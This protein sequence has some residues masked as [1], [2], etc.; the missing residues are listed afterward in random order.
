MCNPCSSFWHIFVAIPWDKVTDSSLKKSKE[1][2]DALIE[3]DFEQFK[4]LIDAGATF[5]YTTEEG[6]SIVHKLIGPE[7]AEYLMYVDQKGLLFSAKKNAPSFWANE[8]GY[9]DLEKKD[10]EGNT[11][12]YYACAK[13]NINTIEMLIKKY[14][15]K[16]DDPNKDGNIPLFE[17]V[18]HNKIEILK[19][20]KENTTPEKWQKMCT[21]YKNKKDESL[22][23]LICK[24]GNREQADYILEQFPDLKNTQNNE[25]QTPLHVAI[26]NKNSDII[27]ILLDSN[28]DLQ[29]KD[30]Y[31]NTSAM[32]ALKDNDIKTVKSI[33]EKE[34]TVLNIPNN[35]KETPLK[36]AFEKKQY[37]LA[38]L[39]INNNAS[40]DFTDKDG[41]TPL[42]YAVIQ[43][44]KHLVDL[45]I[46]KNPKAADIQNNNQ[47]APL[48][49]AIK[50]EAY[51][52][53]ELLIA[54]NAN[55]FFK[56]SEGYT[57]L[58]LAVIQQNIKLVGLIIEKNR[59]TTE[60][61]D[62]NNKT[63]FQIACDQK[64][65]GGKEYFATHLP[66]NNKYLHELLDTHKIDYALF[67]K[68]LEKNPS[69]LFTTTL[70]GNTPLLTAITKNDLDAVKIILNSSE[71]KTI[72]SLVNKPNYEQNTC[73][74][75]A[76]KNLKTNNGPKEKEIVTLLLPYTNCVDEQ[77]NKLI[78]N[79]DGES[80]LDLALD[81]P[82]IALEILNKLPDKAKAINEINPKTGYSPFLTVC[83]KGSLDLVKLFARGDK[84]DLNQRVKKDDSDVNGYTALLLA[85]DEGHKDVYDFLIQQ[86]CAQNVYGAD[87]WNIAMK[88]IKNYKT[89]DPNVT[90]LKR[91][92]NTYPEIIA[93]KTQK[94]SNLLHLAVFYN[95]K[96]AYTLLAQEYPIMIHQSNNNRRSP[97]HNAI[98]EKNLHALKLMKQ[99]E[100][101]YEND[102]PK[103]YLFTALTTKDL[104]IIKLFTSKELINEIHPNEHITPLYYA[105]KNKYNKE[106]I[107][108][109]IKKG[110]D[111]KIKSPIHEDCLDIALKLNDKDIF[112]TILDCYNPTELAQITKKAVII[113]E[114]DY[115]FEILLKKMNSVDRADWF[116]LSIDKEGNCF[117]KHA[118]N[119]NKTSKIL[120]ALQYGLNPT[121]H[122]NDG[123]LSLHYAIEKGNLTICKIL[124]ERNPAMCNA[125]DTQGYNALMLSIKNNKRHIMEYL[126][127]KTMPVDLNRRTNDGKTIIHLAAEYGTDTILYT[128]LKNETNIHSLINQKDYVG[129]TPLH[130]A[131]KACNVE[132]VQR[133]L[134]YNPDVTIKNNT[135]ETVLDLIEKAK[136]EAP[137]YHHYKYS[138]IYAKVNEQIKK[139][140]R[141]EEEVDQLRTTIDTL[142]NTNR[143][144]A[145]NIQQC[146]P[147]TNK[148]LYS[149]TTFIVYNVQNNM[150]RLNQLTKTKEALEKQRTTENEYNIFLRTLWEQK[151][152]KPTPAQTQT[153]YNNSS[154]PIPSA[155]SMSADE[156]D[157]LLKRQS[158]CYPP[159]TEQHQQRQHDAYTHAH[160]QEKTKQ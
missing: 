25:G 112:S 83:K 125:T 133:L 21:Q 6:I 58:H 66:E 139:M 132:T 117:L 97:M 155:P 145:H 79:G 69:A 65:K 45:I 142:Q 22:L 126:L 148:N 75:F 98:H 135:Q 34:P 67:K 88:I 92:I 159:N 123:T 74:H 10:D 59:A 150:S 78:R 71:P 51:D 19:L 52:I 85:A 53:A 62:K 89:L 156:Y 24:K 94:G 144:L 110:A 7:Y 57:A 9:A 127:T 134:D 16:L 37:D 102:R 109:L 116:K 15:V 80:L 146:D 5:K 130:L 104:S 44:N 14:K 120:V 107:D 55:L 106:C 41:N 47:E 4:K 124:L 40:L 46:K 60:I 63:A 81:N 114:D 82:N 119:N 147:A 115:F 54:N 93:Q 86:G 131:A 70:N 129:N 140:R 20:F 87:G 27:S 141:I 68:L 12:L 26:T 136:K 48:N 38:E 158:T 36:I 49:F 100:P 1:L 113:K 121:L 23:F 138:E 137:Y 77:T 108:F 153:M 35:D 128:L 154:F 118:I 39:L 152:Q 56:D 3:N 32:R 17:A 99:H 160:W 29:K 76:L 122:F 101:K 2:Y 84:A 64:W 96:N 72:T 103:D 42:H 11:P 157:E 151:C 111:P 28:V 33:I 105:I 30:T 50:S 18:Q 43:Q 31:G 61:T 90:E 149:P 95:N 91:I 13:N 73:L 8:R 143:Q